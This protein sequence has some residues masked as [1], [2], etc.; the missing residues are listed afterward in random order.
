MIRTG[1]QVV[2]L[3]AAALAIALVTAVLSTWLLPPSPP[4]GPTA[5][6]YV[7]LVGLVAV[8]VALWLTWGWLDRAGPSSSAARMVLRVV[9]A[10]GGVLWVA[11]MAFP[12]L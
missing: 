5:S 3:W 10:T 1:R 4:R 11:A 12:F 9:L 2:L 6:Y 8:G 7:G